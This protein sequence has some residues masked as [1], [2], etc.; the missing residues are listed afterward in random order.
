MEDDEKP[1]EEPMD[2]VKGKEEDPPKPVVVKEKSKPKDKEEKAE[3]AEKAENKAR[4]KKASEKLRE[5]G[6]KAPV[7]RVSD[8]RKSKIVR[9]SER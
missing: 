6:K 8:N 9:V 4:M 2:I 3:K 7:P 1:A 5:N